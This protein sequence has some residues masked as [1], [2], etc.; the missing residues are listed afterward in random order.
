ME[1]RGAVAGGWVLRGRRIG[2]RGAATGWA[3]LP[4][5]VY[6]YGD[7]GCFSSRHDHAQLMRNSMTTMYLYECSIFY[8]PRLPLNRRLISDR[9]IL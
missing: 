4:G 2:G 1:A 9:G 3:C 8:H 5:G 6:D 7:M